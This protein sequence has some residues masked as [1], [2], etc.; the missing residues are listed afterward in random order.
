MDF[1]TFKWTL[2]VVNNLPSIKNQPFSTQS[3]VN[4]T[5]MPLTDV[6]K[7]IK[8]K[9]VIL[10]LVY[11]SGFGFRHESHVWCCKS[12]KILFFPTIPSQHCFGTHF[13]KINAY[14]LLALTSSS[15]IRIIFVIFFIIILIIIIITIII[16]KDNL[17]LVLP[18]SSIPQIPGT[19]FLSYV[20]SCC[21]R[22]GIR[23]Y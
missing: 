1:I 2:I 8:T 12:M 13:M 23:K 16:I 22:P 7:K 17:Y 3:G 15:S 10:N 4:T 5:V 6:I 18:F 11:P 9:K 20:T 14:L 19:L 21:S